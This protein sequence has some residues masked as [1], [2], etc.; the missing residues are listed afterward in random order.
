MARAQPQG[1]ALLHC[2]E[3]VALPSLKGC[4]MWDDEDGD[5]G[6][7]CVIALALVVVALMIW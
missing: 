3:A 6:V 1:C 7:W 2:D 4:P 5:E